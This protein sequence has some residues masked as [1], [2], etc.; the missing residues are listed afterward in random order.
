MKKHLYDIFADKWIHNGKVYLYSDPHFGDIESYIFR[1]FIDEEDISSEETIKR[2]DEMQINNINSTI[3]KDDTI[4]FLGDIGD[5]DCIK[6]IKG[7]KVLLLGNHDSGASNYKREYNEVYDNSNMTTKDVTELY[8]A[9]AIRD[10]KKEKKIIRKYT[11]VYDNHLFDEVYEGPLMIS[12]RIILSHEPIPVEDY[13][14][15]I[16]GH[17]H[18]LSFDYDSKK[19]H[20]NV[21]AEA[22]K[23]KPICLTDLIKQG[24]LKDIPTIHRFTIDKR[25][26]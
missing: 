21:C 25:N 6:K 4:I 19:Q 7:H 18:D 14:I 12:D 22:I 26:D 10:I 1:N 9:Y 11:K 16:H 3:Q 13:M 8:F 23:Y 2:L 24:I 15:N 17:R 5:I 20:Y